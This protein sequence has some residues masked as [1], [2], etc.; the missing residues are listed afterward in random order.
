MTSRLIIK[1]THALIGLRK[2]QYSKK[3]ISSWRQ[4]EKI[5]KAQLIYSNSKIGWKTQ[6]KE[7]K[8][9]IKD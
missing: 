2:S 4:M 7:N 9:L 3:I 1:L 5:M 6:V 8:I